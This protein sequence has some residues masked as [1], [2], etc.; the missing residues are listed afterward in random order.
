MMKGKV[1]EN[2]R[3][4]KALYLCLYV[5]LL[6]SISANCHQFSSKILSLQ[7]TRY[8]LDITLDY[9]SEKIFGKCLLTV[10]N[11]TDQGISYVPLLLYRLLEVKS[12]TDEKGK[13]LPYR[14]D[15][16]TFE[17]WRKLQANHVKVHLHQPLGSGKSLTLAINY[18]GY[19]LGYVEAGWGYVKDHIDKNFT[20]A[21]MDGY[22][23]P[24]VGYPIFKVNRK[25][26]LQNFDYKISVTVPEDL[27]VANG[28]RL[29]EKIPKNGQITYAYT[30]IKP[31]WR[32]DIPIANYS[33]T[34]D[35]EGKLKIFHFPED[36]DNAGAILEAIQK[37][38]TLFTEWFGPA[39]NFQAFTIIEVPEGYGS[40][41]DVTSIIQTADAFKDRENFFE[42]YHEISHIWNARSLDPLPPRFE[43]EGLAMFLQYLVQER[44]DNKKDALKN[45]Y[46]RLRKRFI[47]QC[48][49]NPKCKD[50]PI[51]DYGT[52]DLTDL[53]YTKG[54]LFFYLLFH[55]MGEE[56]F[57]GAMGSFYQHFV[58]TGATAEEFLNHVKRHSKTD[59]DK[60]YEDWIYGTESSRL[61]LDGV[62]VEVLIKRYKN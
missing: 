9:E 55:L 12:I 45:G 17:D 3:T 36:K 59:L 44:I 33:I 40:Q 61:I 27:V 15:I 16:I 13:S 53:S 49:R 39:H 29:I 4:L 7:T 20:M 51:I 58:K 48:E 34:E 54:M 14:Q 21:R 1:M 42:L 35:R 5:T 31:A 18:E 38:L 2:I 30:N 32:I 6:L 25:A 37:T 8:E 23:Y 60:L 50:I 26:G 57:V 10:H 56:N 22:G 47:H 62:P 11:P 52:E 46:D 19:L 28:G 43:S 41:T 24:Q